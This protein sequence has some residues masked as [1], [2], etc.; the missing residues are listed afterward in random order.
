MIEIIEIEITRPVNILKQKLHNR[1]CS[2]VQELSID[3]K[4]IKIDIN[5]ISK[6]SGLLRGIP[7]TLVDGILQV[8]GVPAPAYWERRGQLLVGF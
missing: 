4:I 5:L 3:I 2:L 7:S 1:K 8:S 6:C